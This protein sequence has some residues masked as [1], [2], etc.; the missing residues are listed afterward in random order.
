MSQRAM[1]AVGETSQA[2]EWPT[3]DAHRALCFAARMK[4]LIPALVALLSA[5]CTQT[6]S[7]HRDD[8]S[9]TKRKGEWTNYY[10][11]VVKGDKP[12]QT[13]EEAK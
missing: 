8:F 7:T 13:A 9:P 10:R 11:S 6:I 5:G 3:I 4:L 12:E 1:C 2:R